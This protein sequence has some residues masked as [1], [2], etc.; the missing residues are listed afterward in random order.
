MH[1]LLLRLL[2]LATLLLT[3]C[4]GKP[5]MERLP[6]EAGV[7]AFGDSLTYGTGAPAESSYPAILQDLIKHRVDNAGVP[8]DTTADGLARL[9]S[10]LDEAKP[11]LLILCLGGNDFLKHRPESETRAN[12]QA[13][14]ELAQSRK[15][16]VLLVATPK[17]GYGLNVPPL[18]EQLAEQYGVPLEDEALLEI[19]GSK[20]MKSD[21]VHPNTAGYQAL[22]EAI[23]ARLREL[24]AL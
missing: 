1:T 7:L 4:G 11:A 8:G 22:A 21:L 2:L 14:L 9:E 10:A 18:Y 16:P 19:L 17:P 15:L 20:A 12:L 13:M 23:A 5:K 6:A 3:A 24:G